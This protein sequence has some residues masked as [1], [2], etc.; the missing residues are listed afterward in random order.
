MKMQVGIISLIFIIFFGA[1]AVNKAQYCINPNSTAAGQYDWSQ[2][3]ASTD[4]W[5]SIA[6][7]GSG[8]YLAAVAQ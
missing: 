8:E 4:R 3:T 2:T 5:Y 6:S 7:S 1:L